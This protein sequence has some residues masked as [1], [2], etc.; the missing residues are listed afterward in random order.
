MCV[1]ITLIGVNILSHA[2]IKKKKKKSSGM[3]LSK[4]KKKKNLSHVDLHAIIILLIFT[5]PSTCHAWFCF[6]F[7]KMWVPCL[8]LV[9]W[10]LVESI[11]NGLVWSLTH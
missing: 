3:R 5:I 2:L 8:S 10:Y 7:V 6:I 11:F 4:K 1:F 9:I